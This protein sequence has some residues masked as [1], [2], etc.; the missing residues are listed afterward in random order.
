[1]TDKGAYRG[2]GKQANVG[3]VGRARGKERKKRKKTL[4]NA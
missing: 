1:M 2:E 4:E 3:N